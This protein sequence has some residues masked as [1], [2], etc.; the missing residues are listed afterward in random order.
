[1][2]VW[3]KMTLDEQTRL[4]LVQLVK[5]AVSEAVE[6]HPLS[7]EEVHWVRMAIK[8]EAERADLRKAIIEKSLAGLAW[9]ALAGIGTW[10]VD[11]FVRHWK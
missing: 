11:F 10:A 6:Q 9:M 7:P 5:S 2:E 8:A 3:N 1:M 4:E